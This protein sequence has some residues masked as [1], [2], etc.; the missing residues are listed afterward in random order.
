[1]EKRAN[2]K[3]QLISLR[4]T[5]EQP[6]HDDIRILT[7]K[8][9]LKWVISH[10]KTEVTSFTCLLCLCF[11][12]N[13]PLNSVK[14]HSKFDDTLLDIFEDFYATI[15]KVCGKHA[16]PYLKTLNVARFQGM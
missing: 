3:N 4:R 5:N 11:F 14:I 12:H 7:T 8:R 1:M 2:T 9:C 6:N 10:H 13:D 16:L 15:F